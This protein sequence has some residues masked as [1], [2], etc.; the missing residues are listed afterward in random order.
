MWPVWLLA[1]ADAAINERTRCG[2]VAG[3][4]ETADNMPGRGVQVFLPAVV[5]LSYAACRTAS[6]RGFDFV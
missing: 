1:V 5:Y 3:L 2:L 4:N 6:M